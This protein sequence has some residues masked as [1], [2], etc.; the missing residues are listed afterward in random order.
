MDNMCVLED[1]AV[2]PYFLT[3][4]EWYYE[5]EYGDLKLTAKAPP[6]AIES[7]KEFYKEPEFDKNGRLVLE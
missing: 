2:P 6:K 5:D 3:N 7:Y 4:K 1:R